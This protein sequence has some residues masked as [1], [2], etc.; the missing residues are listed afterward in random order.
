MRRNFLRGEG[1]ETFVFRDPPAINKC[2]K[3]FP[4]EI[5]VGGGLNC[6]K[7]SSN[8]LFL[9]MEHAQR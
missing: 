8:D 6:A 7:V 5:D 2:L 1:R 3:C 4:L 9:D